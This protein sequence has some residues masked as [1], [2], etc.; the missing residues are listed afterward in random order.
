MIRMARDKAEA[1]LEEL[2]S[3]EARNSSDGLFLRYCHG[4]ARNFLLRQTVTALGSIALA[5]FYSPA[6]G[7]LAALLALSGE[8]VDCLVTARIWHRYRAASVPAAARRI[9][10]VTAAFQ[11]MTIAA[12]VVLAWAFVPYD[13]SRLFAAAFLIGAAMNAGVVRPFFRAGTDLRL[14]VYAVT[15]IGLAIHDL[16]SRDFVLQPVSPGH[17]FFVVGATMLAFVTATFI[18]HV[19]HT[20]RVRSQFEHDLLREKHE[21]ALS[22]AAERETERRSRML[23]LVAE[24]ANDAVFITD[25]EGKIEWANDTFTRMTGYS[26][27]EAI[28]RIPGDLLFHNIIDPE[29]IARVRQARATRTAMRIEIPN[30]TKS[31]GLLWLES[32]LT[33]IFTADG[34]LSMT[35]A[36]VRDISDAKEREVELARARSEAETAAQAK[37][38][39]LA[40]M[41]HEIRTPMNGVIATAELL[42]ATDI[43]TDQRLYVDTIVDSGRALLTIINDVLDLSRLQSGNPLIRSEPFDLGECVAG[44]VNLL[45]PEA[46]KKALLLTVSVPENLPQVVGDDGRIRQILLNLIGNGIKF[47]G[48]GRVAVNITHKPITEGRL[49]IVI[50]VSDTGIGIAPDRMDQVFDSFTQADGE[51]ARRYGGT[52]LGLTISRLLARQMG[53]DITVESDIGQ[54]SRFTLT[55]DLAVGAEVAPTPKPRARRRQPEHLL[56]ATANSKGNCVILVAEDNRTNAFIVERMLTAP[57][58]VLHFAADGAAA[59][60][61]F[62]EVRPDIVLMDMSMPVMDGMAATRLIRQIETE[63]PDRGHCPVIALTAN[64]FEDDRTVCLEAGCDDFLSKP[65]A[66]NDLVAMLTRYETAGAVSASG[67]SAAEPVRPTPKVAEV[68]ASEVHKRTRR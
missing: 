43:N 14:G 9:A 8:G 12:C 26:L 38:Q 67:R 41:S 55:L 54:G 37:S 44:V 29:I 51:I 60:A 10:A 13:D 58:R 40:A 46:G 25:P 5:L 57:G 27:Q 24:H 49:I 28:G 31:G 23:A 7:L 6:F 47:T 36:I 2:R 3:F 59:V 66:K 53:G 61:M 68:A 4:R 63:E 62:R 65:V 21:L 33:P 16:A 56:S 1:A 50:I 20:H 18:H 42:S 11:A 39:F 17:G 45:R 48:E 32:S 15:L 19:S 22:R 34:D 64:A 52:G 30:R 35:I